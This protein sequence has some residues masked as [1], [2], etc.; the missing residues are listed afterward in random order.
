[1]KIKHLVLL[2]TTIMLSATL[3]GCAW[4][5]D[6]NDDYKSESAYEQARISMIDSVKP[7]VVIIQQLDGDFGSGIIFNETVIDS[8]TNTKSYAILTVYEN[9]LDVATDQFVVITENEQYAVS[10][11]VTDETYQFAVIYI[12]T[13]DDLDA[14][15]IAQIASGVTVD[16]TAGEDL[17]AIG[18]PYEV[19]MF[20]YVSEGILGVTSYDYK[21]ID[22]LTFIH[23]SETNPGME[24]GPIVSL[25]GNVIGIQLTKVYMSDDSASA[26]PVEGINVALNMNVIAP[27]ISALDTN[28]LDT[29]VSANV[30][31]VGTN[32]IEEHNNLATAMIE[33]VT[34]A[35]V[36]VIGSNGL[37]SGTI[38]KV[39]KL[40]SGKFQYYILTNNHVVRENDEIRIRMTDQT[41]EYAVTDYQVREAYDVAVLR[42]VTDDDLPILDIPPITRSEYVDIVQGQDV[43]AIGTPLETDLHQHVSHGI[44]SV[45]KIS[46]RSVFDLG[47]MHDAEINPGNS[48]GPLFNLNGEV[49]GINVAKITN[50]ND[51][52]KVVYTEGINYSLNINVIAQIINQFLEEDYVESIRS[53]KLGVTV[54]DYVSGLWKYPE[55]YAS[56]VLII[57][58]DYTRQGYKNLEIYDLITSLTIDS[59][60]IN[61]TNIQDLLTSLSGL[62]F[63]T[64]ITLGG[65]RI[66][67]VGD[68]VTFEVTFALS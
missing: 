43:Y 42:V 64:D 47:I 22:G 36:T 8:K 28:F 29:S 19:E 54:I 33:R 38:F 31:E 27:R 57:G 17:Y 65:N 20:N 50:L 67:E 35:V 48:G 11:I 12:E 51:N 2:I 13:T 56:G 32:G 53:P 52:G 63:G 5:V 7:S 49:L 68:V 39:K 58:F 14:Y 18:T 1:M 46:Y 23:S 26:V 6:A 37:G 41:K 9:V 3:V 34:P 40:E 62:P 15:P 59:N 21:M 25:D 45:E 10:N 61:V 55:T 24:G 16:I 4:K 60:T 66:N 44:I 30:I